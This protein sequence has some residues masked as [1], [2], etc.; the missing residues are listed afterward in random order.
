MTTEA[1]RPGE[2][3][4]VRVLGVLPRSRALLLAFG[5]WDAAFDLEGDAVGARHPQT[6]G[7]ASDLERRDMG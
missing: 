7:I 3:L 5:S 1:R 6:G 2:A 4:P